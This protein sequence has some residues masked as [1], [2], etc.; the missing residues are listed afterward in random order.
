MEQE[1][2]P[3][4]LVVDDDESVRKV[5]ARAL[6]W[7]GYDVEAAENGL[8]AL[9]RLQ[10]GDYDCVVL[11]LRMPG[12]DGLRL[13]QAVKAFNPRLAGRI[14]FCTGESVAPHLLWFVESTGNRVVLK[15]FRMNQLLEMCDE[16]CR[17]EE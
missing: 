2:L 6:E 4:V 12:M 7:K 14:V 9:E 15:P 16:V 3:K 10:F 5:V 17:L 1:R 8:Q 11:D 13:Y